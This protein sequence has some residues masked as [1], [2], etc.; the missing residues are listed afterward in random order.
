MEYVRLNSD[1]VIFSF[2]FAMNNMFNTLPTSYFINHF[3]VH[4]RENDKI[5]YIFL[6]AV[7]PDV[8]AIQESITINKDEPFEIECVSKNEIRGCLFTDPSGKS[9][10]M[11]AGA[12][13][14]LV[15]IHFSF[16]YSLSFFDF[17]R[18][19]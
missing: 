18:L 17:K 15:L 5:R 1:Q 13:Y 8:M 14:V 4:L 2:D 16:I 12:S 19:F 10:I 11:W 9:F 6:G 3:E 7:L